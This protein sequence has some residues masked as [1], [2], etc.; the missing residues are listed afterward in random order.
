M[1]N[2]SGRIY[3]PIKPHTQSDVI[4]ITGKQIG[5]YEY[6]CELM[7]DAGVTSSTKMLVSIV[8]DEEAL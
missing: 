4:D 5:T 1:A 2:A 6:W 7:N 8:S 3:S